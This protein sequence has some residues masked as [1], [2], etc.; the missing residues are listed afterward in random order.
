[1]ITHEELT[2][3]TGTEKYHRLTIGPLLGTDG[4]AYLAQKAN[5]FWLIDAIASYQEE[6]SEEGFQVWFLRKTGS[7]A[8]LTCHSDYDSK[9][10]DKY[11]A[12]VTQNIEY[13][14]FPLDEIKLYV[15]NGVV[16]LPSEY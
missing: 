16:M 9:N 3:F 7:K 2:G 10:P 4:V 8:V 12:L 14:D 6:L 13:T 15:Q 5:C 11:P 1:M